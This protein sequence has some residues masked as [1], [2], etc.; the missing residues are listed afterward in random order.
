MKWR[1]ML[2]IR[3]QVVVAMLAL[4]GLVSVFAAEPLV[5]VLILTGQKNHD[6]GATTPKLKSILESTGGVLWMSLS[7]LSSASRPLLQSTMCS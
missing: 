3:F 2:R 6:W 5:R 1:P 4:I 7:I